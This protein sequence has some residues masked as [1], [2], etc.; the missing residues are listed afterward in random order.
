MTRSDVTRDEIVEMLDRAA[1]EHLLN[2]EEFTRQGRNN[3]L[4]DPELR[5]LWLIWGDVLNE[6]PASTPA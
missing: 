1:R 2:L 3:L 4:V 6:A 5:D